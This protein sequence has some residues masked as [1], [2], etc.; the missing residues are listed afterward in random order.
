MIKR[1]KILIIDNLEKLFDEKMIG[2]I[3]DLYDENC[4]SQLIVSLTKEN[5]YVSK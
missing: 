1:H 2:N 3:M 5:K 4:N